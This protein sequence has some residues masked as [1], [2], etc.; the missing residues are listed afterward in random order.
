MIPSM[1]RRLCAWR[2]NDKHDIYALQTCAAWVYGGMI[3]G[4]IHFSNVV[5]G[6]WPSSLLLCVIGFSLL[7]VVTLCTPRIRRFL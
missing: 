1:L 3:G 7:S 4:T 2:P 6:W 5:T